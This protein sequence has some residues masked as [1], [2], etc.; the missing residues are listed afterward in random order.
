MNT[1]KISERRACGLMNVWRSTCRYQ[2]RPDRNKELR[3]RLVALAGERP[4]F[5]YRRLGVLLTRDGITV[6]HKR[7]FRVYREAGLSVKRKQRKEL[8]RE[9]VPQALLHKPNHEWS[10]DFVCDA[11]AGGRMLRMLS[12]VDNFTRECLALEVDTSFSSQR[13]TRVLE[14]VSDSATWRTAGTTNR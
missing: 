11:L 14:E 9:G 4:R 1:F 10:L 6:N 13:V 12:V 8:F 3:E 2:R 5:G 7:L